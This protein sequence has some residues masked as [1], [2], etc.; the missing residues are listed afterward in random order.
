LCT[1]AWCDC[2]ECFIN[3][4]D[5]NP[6]QYTYYHCVKCGTRYR[7]NRHYHE[8]V[9]GDAFMS[10][11]RTPLS[12]IEIKPMTEVP[13]EPATADTYQTCYWKYIHAEDLESA[14]Y[15]LNQMLA[16]VSMDL[17]PNKAGNS[18]VEE[19]DIKR[20]HIILKDIM[21]VIGAAVL[22]FIVVALCILAAVGVL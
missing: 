9:V 8:Y 17:Q 11:Y 3:L 2:Q 22:E 5:E 6:D 18:W 19:P 7:G 21:I 16:Q 20:N 4:V 15:W 1:K 13:A 14:K 10:E 12:P